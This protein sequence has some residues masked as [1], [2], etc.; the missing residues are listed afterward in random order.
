MATSLLPTATCLPALLVD[1]TSTTSVSMECL[2]WGVL[3]ALPV[4]F[5]LSLLAMP[6]K[7][8]SAGQVVMIVVDQFAEVEDSTANP[9]LGLVH[10]IDN[11]QDNSAGAKMPV[12]SVLQAVVL[13]LDR[14]PVVDGVMEQLEVLRLAL[15]KQSKAEVSSLMKT[16]TL[17][18][19]LDPG[20]STIS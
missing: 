6:F 16:W 11:N 3:V 17:L 13:V 15:G 19:V 4:D 2:P 10:T 1:L 18:Q 5:Q 14:V 12:D 20:S 9:L 7:H 8:H